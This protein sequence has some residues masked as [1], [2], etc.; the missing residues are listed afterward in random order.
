MSGQV[1]LDDVDDKDITQN[2]NPTVDENG[3]P[4]IPTDQNDNSDDSNSNDTADNTTVELEID[5]VK[6]TY[7]IDA[8]G[9]AVLNGNVVFTKEQLVAQG[10][11]F[12]EDVANSD[13]INDDNIITVVSE[14]SGIQL[15][16]ENN[17]P[18]AFKA[19]IEG[20][21]EREVYIKNHF[22]QQGVQQALREFYEANPDIHSALA[23]KVKN[24]SLDGFNANNTSYESMI[25][26][27]ETPTDKLKSIYK[28][29][30]MRKGNDSD[31]AD[32]LI[33]MSETDETL[34]TDAAKALNALKESEK[35]E[36]AETLTKLE[37]ERN[38][39]IKEMND[40]YGIT[41][42]GFGNAK[43]L[44]VD[45]S[46]Y[47]LIVK[48]GKIGNIAIPATGITIERQGKPI[49]LNRNDI[50][51]YFYNRV[52]TEDG[53]YTRAEID[54]R[55]RLDSKENW[56]IQGLKNLIGDDLNKLEKQLGQRI[57]VNTVKGGLKL[58]RNVSSSTSSSSSNQN[59]N[60][61]KQILLD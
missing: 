40:Y 45:G 14:L 16:D 8:N 42:D 48:K 30:L 26:D 56:I 43:D 58:R 23:Y 51:A 60:G 32:K 35:T 36:K 21:A 52:Q 24:G 20:I 47:D 34:R 19:G 49:S 7:S 59:N 37:E 10:I 11:E 39:S 31:T 3:N 13:E 50:F 57:K 46:L 61:K 27:A 28:D 33:K 29:F 5:G 18:I 2:Q 17:Q 38:A 4:I 53:A 22:Y 25:V 41:V 9:N 1:L 54:E 6:Q 55:N 44:N 15:V 12:E